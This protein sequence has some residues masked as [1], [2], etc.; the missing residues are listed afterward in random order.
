MNDSDLDALLS[1]NPDLA[2][3][4]RGLMQPA[5]GNQMPLLVTEKTEKPRYV[6][7]DLPPKGKARPR[8]TSNGTFMPHE[9]QKWRTKVKRI[10]GNRGLPSGNIAVRV[11]AVR[12][13]PGSGKNSK[14]VSGE[15]CDTTPDADNVVAAIMDALMDDDSRVV[16]ADCKKV[17]GSRSYMLVSI[18]KYNKVIKLPI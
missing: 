4:N 14:R 7:I 10:W 9:Y 18:T 1:R 8:V 16:Y 17:W 6:M 3:Q 5:R 11:I 15:P 12:A 2:A 13:I